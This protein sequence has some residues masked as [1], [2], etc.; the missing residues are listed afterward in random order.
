MKLECL[1]C[2]VQVCDTITGHE[3]PL[4]PEIVHAYITSKRYARLLSMHNSPD[5]QK[6]KQFLVDC[7]SKK[8]KYVRTL[9]VH[10]ILCFFFNWKW[11]VL[12]LD[13]INSLIS[14]INLLFTFVP[15]GGGM[16]M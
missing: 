7:S 3:M 10:E 13:L 5:Y 9:S 12:T 15:L 11:C 16:E 1:L 14:S 6:Y 2:Y 4:K 8:R